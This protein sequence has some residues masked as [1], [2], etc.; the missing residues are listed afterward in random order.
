[1]Y[2]IGYKYGYSCKVASA[3]FAALSPNNDY[4]GNVRDCARILD[5]VKQGKGVDSVKV[6]TYGNNKRKAYMLA[7]GA[8]PLKLLVADKTRSFYLNILNPSNKKPVTIDGHMINCWYGVKQPLSGLR[9][10]SRQYSLIANDV[11]VFA[12]EMHMIPCEMQ[13]ILRYTWRRINGI[14]LDTQLELWNHERAIAGIGY[15]L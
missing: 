3:V 11:R 14:K 6:S 1:M 13:S 7:L 10:E 9:H 8:D 4:Y 5:T 15:V 12:K 2:D